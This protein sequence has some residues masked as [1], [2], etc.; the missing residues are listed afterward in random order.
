MLAGDDE[1]IAAREC[2][3]HAIA[4]FPKVPM[5]SAGQGYLGTT[6]SSSTQLSE[7][8][9]ASRDATTLNLLT[10]A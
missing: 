3:R 6:L 10:V 4:L 8:Q 9:W 7:R 5:S 2:Q 1:M